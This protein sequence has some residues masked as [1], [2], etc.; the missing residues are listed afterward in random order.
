MLVHLEY[1]VQ[2]FRH[3]SFIRLGIVDYSIINRTFTWNRVAKHQV[4][5][6]SMTNVANILTTK[7]FKN[8][9]KYNF[10]SYGM[11]VF[12]VMDY[13]WKV[14]F[15]VDTRSHAPNPSFFPCTWIISGFLTWLT[16]R[17]P[18]MDQKLLTLPRYLSP[19]PVYSGVRVV[20]YLVFCVVFCRSLGVYLS[21][22]C[23]HCI[24]CPSIFGYIRRFHSII[25]YMSFFC[26]MFVYFFF[27]FF[28]NRNN[29]DN[30]IETE[31]ITLL[32]VTLGN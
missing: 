32:E 25:M 23:W 8:N 5:M 6:T 12:S 2:K 7:C 19:P 16:R 14:P 3:F 20:R 4:A 18:P 28:M 22:I 30:Y 10:Q 13:H 29:N 17:M 11:F 9:I 27:F 21:F 1:M 24:V 26:F 15:F 31:A